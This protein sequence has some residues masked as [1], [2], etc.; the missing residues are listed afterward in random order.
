MKNL[1]LLFLLFLVVLTGC[2]TQKIA[3]KPIPVAQQTVAPAT[4]IFCRFRVPLTLSS[5]HT[6]VS[7][8]VKTVGF[9]AR[10]APRT[11][12]SGLQ[13][14]LP[15]WSI[16]YKQVFMLPV[17]WSCM[18]MIRLLAA[19]R[20]ILNTKVAVPEGWLLTMMPSGPRSL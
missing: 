6:T 8:V 15:D 4:E 14:W 7:P 12:P 16:L 11:T 3:P 20:Q 19:S 10:P 9:G 17:L 18:A 5:Q 13:R 1:N 2:K